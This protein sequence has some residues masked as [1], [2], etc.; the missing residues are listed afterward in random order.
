MKK[1]P[2]TLTLIMDFSPTAKGNI[3]VDDRDPFA[4]GTFTFLEL[5]EPPYLYVYEI[6]GVFKGTLIQGPKV[7]GIS[8]AICRCA[9]RLGQGN[10]NDEYA[11]GPDDELIMVLRDDPDMPGR[12]TYSVVK[13]TGK[14][15]G[16]KGN[17]RWRF[18]I[19]TMTGS[20][21]GVTQID[22]N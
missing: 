21:D 22:E 19:A 20:Y 7:G 5:A 12:G 2:F 4:S 11:G 14:L 18:D 3:L 10:G 6:D 9:V 8:I 15:V 13:G 16:T 1:L 17:G